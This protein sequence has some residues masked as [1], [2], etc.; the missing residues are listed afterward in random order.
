MTEWMVWGV[1][2]VAV[3][4]AG[5]L[6]SRARNTSSYGYHAV[7]SGVNHGCWFITQFLFVGIAVDMIKQPSWSGRFT[8]FLFYA[9]CSTA[10]S[11]TAH[12]LSHTY[13]EKWLRKPGDRP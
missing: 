13:F 8:A 6:T 4:V 1:M 2:L 10:G 3:N 12:Y 9:T 5:T 11:I 7:T